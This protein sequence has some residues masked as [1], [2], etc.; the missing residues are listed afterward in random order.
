M[1]V[2]AKTEYIV[3]KQYIYKQFIYFISTKQQVPFTEVAMLLPLLPLSLLLINVLLPAGHPGFL[4]AEKSKFIQFNFQYTLLKLGWISMKKQQC[5]I[6]N[7]V[8]SKLLDN[9]Q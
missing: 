2:L 1:F 7:E 3:Y 9:L 5:I 4:A 8:S 6:S